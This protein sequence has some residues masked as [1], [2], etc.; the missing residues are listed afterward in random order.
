M[1]DNV[2]NGGQD[3]LDSFERKMLRKIYEAVNENAH[4]RIRF[5]HELYDL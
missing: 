2:Q 3:G 1:D 5:N 4:W